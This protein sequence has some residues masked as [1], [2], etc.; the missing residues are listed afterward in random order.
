[1]NHEYSPLNQ[2]A[3]DDSFVE[4]IQHSSLSKPGDDQ[5]V[6]IKRRSLLFSPRCLSVVSIV[7]LVINALCLL[8]TMRQLFLAA[9]A[10]KPHLKGHTFLDTRDLPRPDP[11][12]GL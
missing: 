3:E 12:Y 9:R 2:V 8:A 1:M 11:Y 10:M 6:Y 5:P 4:K 7:F